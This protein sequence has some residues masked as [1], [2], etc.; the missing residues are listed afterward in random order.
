MNSGNELL[1]SA[2]LIATHGESGT[3]VASELPPPP[4]PPR[5]RAHPHRLPPLAIS[6]RSTTRARTP[7]PE[8]AALVAGCCCC[9]CRCMHADYGGVPNALGQR[10]ARRRPCRSRGVPRAARARGACAPPVDGGPQ[11]APPAGRAASIATPRT[12]HN[13]QSELPS[14]FRDSH[15]PFNPAYHLGHTPSHHRRFISRA[16]AEVYPCLRSVRVD[17]RRWRPTRELHP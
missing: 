5:L 12:A 15:I 1:L 9:L 13:Q 10:R 7:V 6:P 14:P 17:A 2:P 16:P 8:R 11:Y 3:G 4:P